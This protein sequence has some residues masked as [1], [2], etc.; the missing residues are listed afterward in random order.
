MMLSFVGVAVSCAVAC[1][2]R[3]EHVENV[4]PVSSVGPIVLFALIVALDAPLLP[5]TVYEKHQY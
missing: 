3:V 4:S 1:Q 5:A 2:L